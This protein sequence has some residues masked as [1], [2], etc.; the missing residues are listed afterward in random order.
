[1]ALY[2]FD[3][4]WNR[5]HDQAHYSENSNVVK[6]AKAYAGRKSVFQKNGDDE[7]IVDDDNK[8]YF[9]GPGTRHGFI[10]KA[11]GGLMGLGG[12]TRV[13]EAVKRVERKFREGDYVID[14]VG[15]SRGSAI[16]LHFVNELAEIG[17]L[18]GRNDEPVQPRVRFLGLWDTVAAFGIP[19]D[20]GFLKFQKINLFWHLTLPAI[21]DHCF[22]ALALDERRASFQPTRVSGAYEV[23]FRGVHSDIGGGNDNEG[24]NN[25]ALRWM[26]R[27]ALSVRVPVDANL[28]DTLAVDE[29]ATVGHNFDVIADPFRKVL[30]TDFGHYTVRQAADA[31]RM[32]NLPVGC[33]VESAVF[34]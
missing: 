8:A 27:K 17:F 5:E 10:G 7:H 26:L 6:F 14:V 21:V 9:T 4:T 33:P 2:A 19:R 1:M 11:L 20:I 24:R 25:I 22:H 12:R 32:Q 18:P 16:A 3:G 13:A 34:E 31:N 30:E 15:F 23:W 29:N 28:A